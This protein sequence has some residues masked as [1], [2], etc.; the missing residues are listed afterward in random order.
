MSHQILRPSAK[1]SLICHPE[2]RAQPAAE[3]SAGFL[4]QI[5]PLPPVGRNDNQSGGQSGAVEMTISNQ[6]GGEIKRA[7]GMTINRSSG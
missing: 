7:A 3:G 5:S 1:M 6:S 4:W 2:R